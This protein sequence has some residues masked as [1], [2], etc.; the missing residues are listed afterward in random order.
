MNKWIFKKKKVMDILISK[1]ASLT[2]SSELLLPQNLLK[3]FFEECSENNCI[4]LGLDFVSV[5]N[6]EIKYENSAHFKEYYIKNLSGSHIGEIN[7]DSYQ[8][9]REI[10]IKDDQLT[11]CRIIPCFTTLDDYLSML[12]N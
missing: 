5:N 7:S 6:N 2:G 8:W 4:V 11:V 12:H 1:G 9:I 3:D 10:I